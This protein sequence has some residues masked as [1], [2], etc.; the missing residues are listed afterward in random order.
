MPVRDVAL[1]LLIM[2]QRAWPRHSLDADR[3]AAFE[4]LFEELGSSVLPPIA[5]FP[6]PDGGFLLADGWHRVEAARRLGWGE[7][8]ADILEVAY[9][10]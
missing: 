10:S 9:D 5:V 1:P 8:A 7:I 4:D 3:V 6:L 2:I